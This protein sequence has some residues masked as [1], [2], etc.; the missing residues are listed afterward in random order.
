MIE[1]KISGPLSLKIG[2][3]EVN[4]NDGGGYG[5]EWGLAGAI[6]VLIPAKLDWNVKLGPQQLPRI[7]KIGG[8]YDTSAYPD[9][10]TAANGLPLTTSPPQLHQRG[11]F[12]ALA[13]QQVWQR[14]SSSNRGLT[15]LAGYE[16]STPDVSLFKH[17]A[18]VGL[19]DRGLFPWRPDDGPGFELAYGRVSQALTQVQQLQSSLGVPLSNAAPGVE[20]NE[21]IL[22]ANYNFKLYPGLYLMPDLQYI[23]RPSAASTYPNAWVAGFQVSARL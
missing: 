23:I 18:F 14:D 15:V 21:I 1:S 20:T 3:Y 17:F 10:Y 9:W 22:E 7:Y 16:Y 11:T 8:S 2:A 6:G 13:Q 12:N 4:P 19:V 5:F